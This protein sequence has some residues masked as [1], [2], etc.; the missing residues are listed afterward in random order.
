MTETRPPPAR[1]SARRQPVFVVA[2]GLLCLAAIGAVLHWGNILTPEGPPKVVSVARPASPNGRP[3]SRVA[4]PVG[5]AADHSSSPFANIMPN[6]DAA[7]AAPSFDVV[8]VDRAGRAVIAGRGPAGSEV[9]VEAGGKVIGTTRADAAGEWVLVPEQPLPAGAGAITLSAQLPNGRRVASPERVLVVVPHP[10]AG[11]PPVAVLNGL[12]APRLVEAPPPA[13]RSA[14][15]GLDLVQYSRNGAVQLAGRAAA[16]ADVRVYL[17]D[18]LVGD[19]HADDTGH[20][21]LSLTRP[22]SPGMH[23]LRFDQVSP[24]GQVLAR[25]ALP[26]DRSAVLLAGAHMVVVQPG[27]CLWLIAERAYGS[28]VRYTLIYQANQG[29]I[30]DPNLIYPGQVFTVPAPDPQTKA[31]G[32]G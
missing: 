24:S 8:R 29:Q 7:V 16:G 26:F 11:A 13:G 19:A 21:S 25:A 32:R 20:W 5:P 12:G 22:V 9:K 4:A 15:L 6:P 27:Q 10:G 17:D 3:A 14:S 23:Q 30:R 18:H 1:R 2:G 28:G 31:K